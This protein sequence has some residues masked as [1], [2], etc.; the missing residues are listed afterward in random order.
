MFAQ[1]RNRV[2]PWK[3]GAVDRRREKGWK[4]AI[5]TGNI[6]PAF[7]RLQLRV[8]PNGVKVVDFSVG[9][10][11]SIQTHDDLFGP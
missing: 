4:L 7:A 11:R 1:T 3:K 6:D 5:W 10:K 8:P 2:H 9:D